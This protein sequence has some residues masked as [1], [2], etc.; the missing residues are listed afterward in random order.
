MDINSLEQQPLEI[1]F[2]ILI[3]LPYRDILNVCQ[4]STYLFRLCQDENFWAEKAYRDFQLPQRLFSR[5]SEILGIRTFD[6][7]QKYLLSQKV[8]LS[9]SKFL[10]L[11]LI[12]GDL[13]LVRYLLEN[14]SLEVTSSDLNILLLLAVEK[15]NLSILKYLFDFGEKWKL[16]HSIDLDS[17]LE[18]AVSLGN[19]D[20]VVYLLNHGA[21]SQFALELAINRGDVDLVS[22]L[23]NRGYFDS[24]L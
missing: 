2:R 1:I 8:F 16:L 7:R 10:G 19:G 22:E 11:A 17:L 9:P 20:I 5:L 3:H 4:V 14:T 15:S 23:R 6:A 12:R 13:D 21:D 18:T 24:E